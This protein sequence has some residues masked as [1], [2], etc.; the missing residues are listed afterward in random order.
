MNHACKVFRKQ[1][2]QSRFGV[3]LQ[4]QVP[5]K[6]DKSLLGVGVVKS[7][8]DWEH[9]HG[10]HLNPGKAPPLPPDEM[11]SLVYFLLPPS[12]QFRYTFQPL[13]LNP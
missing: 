3:G 5:K 7:V 10:V 4:V 12:I 8:I 13:P 11:A 6:L 9:K 1:A 2:K